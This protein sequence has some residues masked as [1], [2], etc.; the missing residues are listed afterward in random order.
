MPYILK[1]ISEDRALLESASALFFLNACIKSAEREGKK[2]KMKVTPGKSRMLSLRARCRWLQDEHLAASAMDGCGNAV[3]RTSQKLSV[4]RVCGLGLGR[5][6][7]SQ[8]L[9]QSM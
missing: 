1:V 5:G 2:K 7:V 9:I 4:Q 3:V 6:T 8:G